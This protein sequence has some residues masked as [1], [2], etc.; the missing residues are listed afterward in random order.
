M[1]AL[2]LD[3]DLGLTPSTCPP[4]KLLLLLQLLL[5]LVLLLER[6]A[7]ELGLK[8]VLQRVL[9]NLGLRGACAGVVALPL[10]VEVVQGLV[11]DFALL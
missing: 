4:G 1:E 3:G 7:V 8:L 2:L 6:D 11:V 9:G 5:K 10:L